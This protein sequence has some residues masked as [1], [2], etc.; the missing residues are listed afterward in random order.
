MCNPDVFQ[1]K[2]DDQ[3][4]SIPKKTLMRDTGCGFRSAF[5]ARLN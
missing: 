3:Y 2:A 4:R 5:H 1:T